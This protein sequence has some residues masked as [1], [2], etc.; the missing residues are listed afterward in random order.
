MNTLQA[1]KQLLVIE[2]NLLRAKFQ[3]DLGRIEAECRIM[4]ERARTVASTTSVVFAAWSAWSAW[5]K[6]RSPEKHS[7][8]FSRIL[9][10][11]RFAA[12]CWALTSRPK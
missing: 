11:G 5:R 3:E 8:W 12:S 2:A 4:S 6:R 10:A 7:S 9:A 1:R